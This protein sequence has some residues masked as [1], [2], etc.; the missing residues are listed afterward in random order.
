MRQVLCLIVFLTSLSVV[1]SQHD[2][3]I[4]TNDGDSIATCMDTIS[5]MTTPPRPVKNALKTDPFS[6]PSKVGV[7]KYSGF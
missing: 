3:L 2:D 1:Y 5:E 4:I 7:L 6:W